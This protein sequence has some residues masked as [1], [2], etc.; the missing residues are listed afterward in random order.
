MLEVLAPLVDIDRIVENCCLDFLF[1]MYIFQRCLK[2]S[3][4][5]HMSS[6]CISYKSDLVFRHWWLQYECMP[7]WWDLCRWHRQL[8]LYLCRRLQ[9]KYMWN[10]YSQHVSCQ[11]F[12]RRDVS[13]PWGGGN[14]V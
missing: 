10:R 1:I 12:N 8:H 11:I 14:S 13:V 7:E 6:I 9:W 4:I 5:S 2:H 3:L